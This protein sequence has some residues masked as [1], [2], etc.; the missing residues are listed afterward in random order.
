MSL[1]PWS[2]LTHPECAVRTEAVRG[3]T[4]LAGDGDDEAREM[5]REVVRR[6]REVDPTVYVWA[7]YRVEWFGDESIVEPLLQALAGTDDRYQVPAA[8]A[9][10][11]L[12]V[13]A[14]EPMIVALLDHPHIWPQ[15]L[16]CQALRDLGATTAVGALARKLDHG[17]VVPGRIHD[18][19]EP[20]RVAACEALLGLGSEEAVEAL[21]DAFVTCRRARRH[22]LAQAL[23][24]CGPEIHDRLATTAQL[25]DP[26]IRYWSA[27]ALGATRD[28]RF[29]P[30][31]TSLL[32]DQATTV[33]GARVSTAARRA[34]RPARPYRGVDD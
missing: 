19:E 28:A 7:L 14:A 1:V 29:H 11:T 22:Y 25:D 27:V 4:T 16:A 21:W 17:P 10:G 34:L 5:L 31:L 20:V 26:T 6:Y 18:A 3:L 9:C 15:Q 13:R 30:L 33:T 23:A 32:E 12:G 24:Q 8:A 2:Q